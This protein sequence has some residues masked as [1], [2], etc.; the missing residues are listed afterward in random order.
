[1]RNPALSQLNDWDLLRTFLGVARA[2]SMQGAARSLARSRPTVG[3]DIAQLER[4]VGCK[5][6]LRA[7]SGV[8]LTAAG[9]HVFGIAESM[10]SQIRSLRP[11]AATASQVS[12]MVRFKGSDGFGGYCLPRLLHGFAQSYPRVTLDLICGDPLEPADLARYE[13]DFTLMY[14]PPANSDL[15]IVGD[16]V[17]T[18]SP[19]VGKGYAAAHALPSKPEDLL[20]HPVLLHELFLSDDGPGQAIAALMRGHPQVALR[21]NSLQALTRSV[22]AGLG[23]SFLPRMVAAHEPDLLLLDIDGLTARIPFWL[24]CRADFAGSSAAR[25]LLDHVKLA[26]ADCYAERQSEPQV[27][28]ALSARGCAACS[29]ISHLGEDYSIGTNEGK[30]HAQP[31]SSSLR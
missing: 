16:G 7:A 27:A 24:V 1:M 22:R 30:H 18:W 12:G 3:R 11:A 2:G 25:A 31:C 23:L 17:F 8:I 15:A 20:G 10:E 4:N 14:A 29:G 6:F 26:L 13:A 9:R 5:L 21:T 28:G 19:Y